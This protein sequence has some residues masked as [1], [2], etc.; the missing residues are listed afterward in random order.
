MK[1]EA[2]PIFYEK[3][4]YSQILI[5]AIILLELEEIKKLN[6]QDCAHFIS[7][8]HSDVEV[9]NLFTASFNATKLLATGEGGAVCTNDDNLFKE[10]CKNKLDNGYKF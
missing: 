7:N 10:L 3:G 9:S 6:I 8:N 2:I 1:C 4:S 5:K